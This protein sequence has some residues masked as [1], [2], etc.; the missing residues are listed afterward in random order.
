MIMTETKSSTQTKENES[1]AE[2]KDI[3]NEKITKSNQG[4][5]TG[6]MRVGYHSEA[7]NIG[8]DKENTGGMR[9]GYHSEAAN[10]SGHSRRL[11]RKR[12]NKK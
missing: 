5:Y 11:H 10:P 6:G 1:R 9:V 4:V 2:N 3:N 8:T 7:A 12:K